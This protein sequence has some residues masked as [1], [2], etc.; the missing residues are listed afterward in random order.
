MKVACFAIQPVTNSLLNRLK[1]PLPERRQIGLVDHSDF[2][3]MRRHS[4]DQ[5]LDRRWFGSHGLPMLVPEGTVV[6][7]A[8]AAT[9]ASGLLQKVTLIVGCLQE[10]HASPTAGEARRPGVHTRN[11]TIAL[12]A[13]RPDAPGCIKLVAGDVKRRAM[14]S[15]VISTST[16]RSLPSVSKL[17]MS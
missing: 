6:P 4:G 8:A 14:Q 17:K 1:G 5:W 2:F 3:P 15:L 7:R 13:S 12:R 9:E 10:T 16:S 11:S